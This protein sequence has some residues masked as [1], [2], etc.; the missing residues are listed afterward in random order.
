MDTSKLMLSTY[1]CALDGE[2]TA[3]PK[4]T[5]ARTVGPDIRSITS[6]VLFLATMAN[7]IES[8]KSSSPYLERQARE[9]LLRSSADA[10]GFDTSAQSEFQMSY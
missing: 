2:R 3:T 1:Q 6:V 4:Q 10:N 8:Q 9:T 5:K 7:D